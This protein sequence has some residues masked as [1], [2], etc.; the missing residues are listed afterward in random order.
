MAVT[1]RLKP[2]E[3][4]PLAGLDRPDRIQGF[5]DELEYSTEKI[6]RAPTTVLRDRRAHCLDGALLAAC[7]LERLGHPPQLVDLRAVRDDDHVIAIY[8]Q[9]GRFGA[10]AKSNVVGLRFREPVYHSLR[11][12][13]MSY[14]ELYFNTDG[15]K[16]LRS[17]SPPLDLGRFEELDWRRSDKS[18][19]E[20][21]RCLDDVHHYSLLDEWMIHNLS[22]VDHRSYVAL[23]QGADP[24]GLYAGDR[25]KLHRRR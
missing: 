21:V 22:P 4:G 24:E 2:R 18:V 16:T 11:E 25:L 6:Y 5:L 23:M 7:A 8:R 19:D 9:C 13:V 3:V 17:Y 1:Y 10:V 20:I 12:L 15:E 14:F